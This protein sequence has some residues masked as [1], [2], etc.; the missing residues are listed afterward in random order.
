MDLRIHT[1]IRIC[2]CGVKISSRQALWNHAANSRDC[3]AICDCGFVGVPAE[4]LECICMTGPWICQICN[5]TCKSQLK[6]DNHFK[7]AH[8]HK[9]S[10]QV[11]VDVHRQRCRNNNYRRRLVNNL[12]THSKFWEEN[13][14]LQQLDLPIWA[15]FIASQPDRARIS[16]QLCGIRTILNPHDL[17]FDKLWMNIKDHVELKAQALFSMNVNHSLNDPDISAIVRNVNGLFSA[18]KNNP[19]LPRIIFMISQ[20]VVFSRI[21][22]NDW[23]TLM[24]WATATMTYLLPN[25]DFGEWIAEVRSFAD[26]CLTYTGLRAQAGDFSSPSDRATWSALLAEMLSGAL[27]E[28]SLDKSSLRCVMKMGSVARGI[29][30]IWQFIRIFLDQMLPQVKSWATGAPLD[31]DLAK[32]ALEGAED[33]MVEVETL[34]SFDNVEKLSEDVALLH[35]VEVAERRGRELQVQAASISDRN[36]SNRLQST[37]ACFT[38]PL[39]RLWEKATAS[40]AGRG[41]PKVEPLVALISGESGVGKS[42]LSQFLAIDMLKSIKDIPIVDDR[43]DWVKHVYVRQVGQEFWDGYSGQDIVVYDDAFQVRDSVAVPNPELLEIIRTGNTSSFPLHR[44]ELKDKN[45]SFFTSKAVIVSSNQEKVAVESLVKP[46]AVHRRFDIAVK[47][48]VA[49][50]YRLAGT[51]RI[52]LRKVEKILGVTSSPNIYQIWCFDPTSGH[53]DFS[54]HEFHFDKKGRR[55]HVP[56]TYQQFQQRCCVKLAEKLNTSYARMAIF[57]DYARDASNE[58]EVSALSDLETQIGESQT[59]NTLDDAEI[60]L[61][62]NGENSGLTMDLLGS[63]ASFSVMRSA[64][65]RGEYDLCREMICDER[66]RTAVT[67]CRKTL[68]DSGPFMTED[69]LHVYHPFLRLVPTAMEKPGWLRIAREHLDAAHDICKDWTTKLVD[70]VMNNPGIAAVLALIPVAFLLYVSNKEDDE[71]LDTFDEPDTSGEPIRRK[72]AEIAVSGDPKTCKARSRRIESIEIGHSGDPRTR[73]LARHTEDESTPPPTIKVAVSGD[74]GL[75]AQA[76]IDQNSFELSKRILA[77]AYTVSTGTSKFRITMIQGRTGLTM[78]HSIPS[79]G[80]TLTLRNAQNPN[81][82]IVKTAECKVVKSTEHDVALIEFPRSMRDHA[83]LLPN[84]C[85]TEELS[86]FPSSGCRSA[87]I[88]PDADVYLIKYATTRL[89]TKAV[90]YSDHARDIDYRLASSFQYECEMKDGDCGAILVAINPSM[91]RKILGIH[92]AGKTGCPIGHAAVVSRKIID[93]LLAQ[94][95]EGAKTEWA[96]ALT[97]QL[98]L[99]LDLP[100]GNFT[101]IGTGHADFELGTT[102]IIP[103]LIQEHLEP[104]LTRPALLRKTKDVDPLANGVKKAGGATPL[105]NKRWLEAAVNSVAQ[106]HAPNE[107]AAGRRVLTDVEA[108]Q[109]VEGDPFAPPIK[110]TTSAGYPYKYKG[111]GSSK[112]PW[113]GEGDDWHTQPEVEAELAKAK[114]HLKKGK[115]IPT[116]WIDSLKD[117]RRPHAKVDV[118]KTRVFAAGPM[119]FTILFRQYFL[120]F[121]SAAARYRNHNEISVGTNVYSND[122]D[123]IHEL[124]TCQ[125]SHVIAGDFSNFDG[126]LHPDILWGVFDIMNSW[127]DDDDT[128]TRE[129]LFREIVFSIH[130]YRGGLYHWT[131][132]QPSGCP[133]TAVINSLYNCVSMRY[134]WMDLAPVGMKNM[135]SFTENVTMVAYGDDNIVNISDV[136]VGWFNQNSIAESYAS[137]GMTYTDESKNTEFAATRT[138]EHVNYLKRKFVFDTDRR[139]CLAPLDLNTIDETPKWVRKSA[140]V[141]DATVEN[142]EGCALEWS[143]HG[144]EIYEQRVHKILE[145]CKL[146]N[147]FPKMPTWEECMDDIMIMTGKVTGRTD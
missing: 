141:E 109:G 1:N 123:N 129:M 131:H 48:T 8:K 93:P 70:W 46:E 25:I 2:P 99:P 78:A 115:R 75:A 26:T 43:P 28:K 41:G 103:S 143:L 71:I 40:G 94:I 140:S 96:E 49:P 24:A 142:V 80:K 7:T 89:H 37:L 139:K 119:I 54:Q 76:Q 105:L 111:R 82:M 79:L 62:L 35:R 86:A 33:F 22:I 90:V 29:T 104:P 60:D 69:H 19:I 95:S 74:G 113:L 88:L 51:P 81:G 30:N 59:W 133:A 14:L 34:L 12:L 17:N 36:V 45:K 125:G 66:L 10:A 77:N 145:A 120:A 91:R 50:E 84:I 134:V 97:A 101:T 13:S 85:S 114:E 65:A 56:W 118:G 130:A 52:D 107:G 38:R 31:L 9:L 110:R 53:L 64:C 3:V 117:E 116:I 135:R 146:E 58:P 124:M 27:L 147:L 132:S 73:K 44:A 83:N 128:I 47:V 127:Y 16:V 39:A 68:L 136:V 11:G 67:N 126:T 112:V 15:G 32:E 61:A 87:L 18:W 98:S 72:N 20:M 138:I 144:K 100:E 42:S 63:H 121:M 92:V 5:T 137:I 108:V 6:L 23:T 4:H 57:D 21:G 102:T 122:W 55:H 106:V